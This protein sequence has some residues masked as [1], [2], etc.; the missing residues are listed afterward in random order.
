MAGIGRDDEERLRRFLPD[1]Q[2]NSQLL[3]LGNKDG[4]VSYLDV[5]FLDPYD[6][7]KKASG[8]F[9]RSLTARDDAEAMERISR[10][11]ME[12]AGELLRP[13]KSE[14]L[15]SGAIV[16]VLRNQDATGRPIYNPQDTGANIAA[17]TTE[18]IWKAF[19][20]GAFDVAGRVWKAGVGDVSDSGRAY[21]LANEFGGAA[22]GQRITEVNVEQA[23][24]F[25]AS[26][27]SRDIR[28]ASSLFTREFNSKGTRSPEQI[29][30]AYERANDATY[31]LTADFRD[32]VLAAIGLG[33]IS[34]KKAEEILKANRIG[35]EDIAMIRSG[36]YKKYEPS[37]SA[38]KIAPQDRIKAA[39]AAVKR[40][41]D[42]S[43]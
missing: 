6:Y 42:T 39:D 26:K 40:A 23:L 31:S 27:F 5:S 28:D 2:K 43:L 16:D 36:R 1:W 20:P 8:A 18:R 24:G 38:K 15:V 35:K 10:G 3:L 25:K 33:K 41:K 11:A 22:L 17:K 21:N 14:Q 4:K 19:S 12:A 30:D 32:D 9:V 37:D 29:A 34:P 13:F 7:W